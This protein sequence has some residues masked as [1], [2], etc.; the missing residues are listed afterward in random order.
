MSCTPLDADQHL[1]PAPLAKADLEVGWLTQQHKVGTKPFFLDQDTYG[2]T[3]ARL[4][5]HDGG[6]IQVTVK[7]DARV[8]QRLGAVD[9]GCQPA[10]HVAGT[11][12]VQDAVVNHAVVWRSGPAGRITHVDRVHVAVEEELGAMPGAD[13]ANDAADAAGPDIG[14]PHPPHLFGDPSRQRTLLSGQTG[15]AHQL[16][17]KSG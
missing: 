10:L 1:D 8:E 3:L 16:L 9:H 2:Q 12:S 17:D 11:A 7:L 6:D 5:L 15:N 14:K 13:V 4:F